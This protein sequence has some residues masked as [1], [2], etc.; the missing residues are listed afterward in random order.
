MIPGSK[1]QKADASLLAR[2]FLTLDPNIIEFDKRE[3]D[4]KSA[5]VIRKKFDEYQS[6][7]LSSLQRF[8]RKLSVSGIPAQY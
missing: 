2:G 6:K 3:Q 4:M 8:E 5:A 1:G 7:K